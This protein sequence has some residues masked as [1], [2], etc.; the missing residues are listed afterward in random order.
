MFF[1]YLKCLIES[2]SGWL[3]QVIAS[4][5]WSY[6]LTIYLYSILIAKKGR[7]VVPLP[8]WRHTYK[9]LTPNIHSIQS[10]K[11]LNVRGGED[12]RPPY[13]LLKQESIG[14]IWFSINVLRGEISQKYACWKF[15]ES[16]VYV[17]WNL[18][19]FFVTVQPLCWGWEFGRYNTKTWAWKLGRRSSGSIFEGIQYC[20]TTVLNCV[21][22]MYSTYNTL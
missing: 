1:G 2:L 7:Q 4:K 9:F 22:F 14:I 20:R 21:F 6:I 13:A 17:H 11:R 15:S 3:K 5:R 10:L 12:S 8:I 18:S 16:L 19:G